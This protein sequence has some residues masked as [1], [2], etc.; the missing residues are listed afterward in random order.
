[1]KKRLFSFGKVRGMEMPE[2]MNMEIIHAN[3]S[4]L[5][6]LWGQ[7]NRS[8]NKVVKKEIEDCFKTYAGNYIIRFGKY[9][10]LTLKDIDERNR[11]YLENYLIH[12]D[13]EEIRIV[14][15]TY[16]KYHQKKNNSEYNNF[17]QKTYIY[18]N[19][20]KHKINNC[21]QLS[22]EHVVKAM[23]YIIERGKFEHCPWG[24]DKKSIR[25]QHAYLKKGT[26]GSYFV[27]CFKC[28]EKR[29]FIKFICEKKGYSFTEAL[30]WIAGILGIAVVN[31]PKKDVVELK[32]DY[33]NIEE[34]I[35]IEK[36]R[37][38]EI[39][40]EGFGFNKGIYPPAFYKRGYTVSD[41]EEMEVYFAGRDCTNALK[42]GY[43]SW[44]KI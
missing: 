22:I 41:G 30:E 7:Y 20:L 37:L 5:Q 28:G 14:V 10:G 43:V 9:K 19:E 42:I 2:V 27:G 12:N 35:I 23:G 33:I 32:K 24:C 31:I 17:Q 39:S 36:Q 11:S 25:Y 26:D 21:S 38:P 1:M 34:E 15:K 8:T 44:L 3:Y 18:Y 13:N 40:L 4:G 16:L 6:Y 29:N